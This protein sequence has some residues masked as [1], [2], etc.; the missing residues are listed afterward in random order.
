MAFSEITYCKNYA[1]K[2]FISSRTLESSVTSKLWLK[3]VLNN[4]TAN[5]TIFY[6][7]LEDIIQISSIMDKF[8]YFAVEIP[9]LGHDILL[10]AMGIAKLAW[11]LTRQAVYEGPTQKDR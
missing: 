4:T 1:K 8:L 6:E 9:S 5:L 10:S 7:L 2:L 3:F 11:R